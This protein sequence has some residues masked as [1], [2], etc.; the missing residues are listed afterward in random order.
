MKIGERVTVELGK[1]RK[2]QA[3]VIEI[4]DTYIR[5]AG[6][7]EL[8]RCRAEGREPLGLCFGHEKI[9]GK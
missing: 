8:T 7:E 9:V 1:G 6:D 2:Q 4:K 5:V 3:Q